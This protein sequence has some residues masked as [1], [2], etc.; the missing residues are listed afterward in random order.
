MNFYGLKAKYIQDQLAK[1]KS[2]LKQ[3]LSAKFG[4][5]LVSSQGDHHKLEDLAIWRRGENLDGSHKRSRFV[6][7]QHQQFTEVCDGKVNSTACSVI[8]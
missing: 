1:K 3:K 5:V 4:S 8:Q 6:Q 2:R 7:V